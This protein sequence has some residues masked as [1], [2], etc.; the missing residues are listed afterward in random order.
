M[1]ELNY[2]NSNSNTNTSQPAATQHNL[3]KSN[4]NTG[5]LAAFYEQSA[6]N[7]FKHCVQRRLDCCCTRL[8]SLQLFG[9]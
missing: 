2:P 9:P 6:S 4:A 8:Q 3:A 1:S 7:S 5:R